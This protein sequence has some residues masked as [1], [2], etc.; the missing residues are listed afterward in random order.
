MEDQRIAYRVGGALD[1][2]KD[3]INGLFFDEQNDESLNNKIEY[4][5]NN[6]NMFDPYK[7]RQSVEKFDSV[8]FKENIKSYIESLSKK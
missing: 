6:I 3:G 7:I 2:I 1:Y 5:E 4:F 8:F